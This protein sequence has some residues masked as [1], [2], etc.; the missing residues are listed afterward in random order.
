MHEFIDCFQVNYVFTCGC[1]NWNT[2]W[3]FAE[4]T[5]SL[6]ALNSVENYSEVFLVVNAVLGKKSN[7]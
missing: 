2:C 4:Q 5:C 6:D 3:A 1:L 7:S